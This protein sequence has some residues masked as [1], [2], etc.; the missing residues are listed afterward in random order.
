M[1]MR[2]APTYFRL[3]WAMLFALLLALRLIG[4]TGYMPEFEHGRLTI[5]VCPD[6]DPNAPLALGRA[7]HHHGHGAA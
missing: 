6:A 2:A 5:I 1:Q 3:A 7:H 4:S